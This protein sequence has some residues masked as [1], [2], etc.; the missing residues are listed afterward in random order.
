MTY[1]FSKVYKA[2]TNKTTK[3]DYE[4]EKVNELRNSPCSWVYVN[5]F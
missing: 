5:C 4:L 3:Y 1:N 2:Y